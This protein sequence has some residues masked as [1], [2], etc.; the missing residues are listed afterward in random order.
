MLG[1]V[2]KFCIIT[3]KS[4]TKNK[5]HTSQS[6]PQTPPNTRQLLHREKP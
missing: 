6:F 5:F 4:V 2:I 3:P 1:A